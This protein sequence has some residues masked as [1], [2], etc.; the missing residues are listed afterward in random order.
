LKHRERRFLRQFDALERMIPGARG[1]LER[2]R[3]NRWR[4]VRLPLALVLI[5]GGLLSFLPVLGIWMLPFGLL[6]LAIDLPFLRGPISVLLIR[7]RR[8]V[9]YWTRRWRNRHRGR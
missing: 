2:L 4:L 7:S 1:P 6:L 9:R 8:L 3:S 5:T